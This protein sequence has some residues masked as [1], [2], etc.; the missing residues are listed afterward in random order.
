MIEHHAQYLAHSLLFKQ[1]LIDL[2]NEY[3]DCEV[4]V[5]YESVCEVSLKERHTIFYD[6]YHLSD[7]GCDLFAKEMAKHLWNDIRLK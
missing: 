3:E 7:H 2:S 4:V 6:E 1:F 5:P